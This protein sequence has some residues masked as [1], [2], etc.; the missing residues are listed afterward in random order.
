MKIGIDISQI[1]YQGTGV[2][3]YTHALVEALLKVDQ[4]NHYLL[5]GSSFRRRELIKDFVENLRAGNARPKISFLPPKFLEF[6]WNG[7]HLFPIENFTGSLDVF[8]SSDWLEPP[9]RTAKKVTTIH[10]FAVY[11]YPETFVSRG[12]HDIIQNQKRRLHFV[13]NYSDMI[14]AV[15]EATKKDALEILNIPEEKIKVIYEAGDPIYSK[16]SLEEIE[17]TKTKYKIKDDYLLCVG[18]REPRK[19]LDRVMMAFVEITTANPDLT[20]VIAGKYGWGQDLGTKYNPP[21]GGQNTKFKILGFVEKEDL[22]RLYSGAKAFLYPSLYEGFG[23]PILE[24]MNCDC[25][26]ITSNLG[27]M[28]EIAGGAAILV[29]PRAV[30]EIASAISK[31]CRSSQTREDLV[32]KGRKRVSQF[33]WEKAAL[34]TLEAYRQV[35]DD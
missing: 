13:K 4:D 24:A 16:R 35:L 20:L 27:A 26:V 11:K 2:A 14:I 21:T 34:H 12:G 33:S 18:T 1:V 28:K 8:H 31:V 6:L 23:L 5:F 9:T 7:V 17:E 25:P 30:E 32:A 15:S 22:A 10:D 29:E 19:N 3:T